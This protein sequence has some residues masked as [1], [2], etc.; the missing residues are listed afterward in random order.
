MIATSPD[1][2]TWTDR[3]GTAAPTRDCNWTSI[4]WNGSLFCAVSYNTSTNGNQVMTSPDGTTWTARNA[5]HLSQWRGISWNGTV[6][7]AV[8]NA[9]GSSL[10]M[11][12]P[13]GITWTQR[14]LDTGLQT[15]AISWNGT[16]FTAIGNGNSGKI[17]YSEDGITWTV[18]RVFANDNSTWLGLGWNGL[19]PT[20]STMLL[21]TPGSA[22]GGDRFAAVA[23]T[24]TNRATTSLFY[25][26]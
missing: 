21:P 2:T 23:D 17:A 15:Q 12:S 7:A 22:T 16:V 1:G 26:S 18:T 11:S 13:D 5:S 6:F 9:A 14:T 10:A 8:S 4:A 24:G 25:K 20:S 19:G 3:T